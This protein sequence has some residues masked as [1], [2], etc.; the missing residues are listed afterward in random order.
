MGKIIDEF[1][2]LR[3]EYPKLSDETVALLLIA[4]K[5]TYI[6][7]SAVVLDSQQFQEIKEQIGKI[8]IAVHGVGQ[9]VEKCAESVTNG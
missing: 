4:E 7:D 6:K 2:R 8:G 3:A 5:L 1:S 9:M